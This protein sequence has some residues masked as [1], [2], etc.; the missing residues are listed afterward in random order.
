MLKKVLALVVL[1]L[2]LVLIADSVKPTSAAPPPPGK[3]L[4][5]QYCATCHGMDGTGNGPTAAALKKAPADLT[6]IEKVNGKFPKTRVQRIISGDDA[7]ESHGSREM[8][9]WGSVFRRRGGPGGAQL[10]VYNLANYLE[11]LQK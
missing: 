7:V 3:K 5:V 6:K 8:P 11:T 4:F 1:A 10:D 9:V 2:G